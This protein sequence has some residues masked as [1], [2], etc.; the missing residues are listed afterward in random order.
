MSPENWAAHLVPWTNVSNSLW[1][2]GDVAHHVVGLGAVGEGP[3]DGVAVEVLA[4]IR[5]VGDAAADAV[6]RDRPHVLE[7]ADLVDLVD[8][9]LGP[10]AAGDPVEMHEVA[11]LQEEFLFVGRLRAHGDGAVHAVGADQ[12]DLAELA[13]ADPLDQLLAVDRVAA[14]QAGGDLEVLLFGGLAASITGR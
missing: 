4:A 6:G 14:H 13:V 3:L 5:A 12:L 2:F 10:Q 8:V 11:D 7:P 1:Q 9:H